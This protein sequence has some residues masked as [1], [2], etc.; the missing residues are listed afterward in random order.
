MRKL[1]PSLLLSVAVVLSAATALAQ[2]SKPAGGKSLQSGDKKFVKD[3]AEAQVEILHLTELTGR[4]ESPGSP[5]LKALTKPLATDLTAAYGEIGTIGQAKGAEMPETKKGSGEKRAIEQLKKAKPEEFDKGF[6]KMLTK[7]TKKYS[8]LVENGA[9][10]LSDTELK[11]W[12]EK[13]APKF[14]AHHEALDKLEEEE[15]KKK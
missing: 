15:S 5:G 6:L 10:S 1:I 4:E 9:K 14:K 12:A 11:G 2:S 3:A 13:W 7:E 8:S